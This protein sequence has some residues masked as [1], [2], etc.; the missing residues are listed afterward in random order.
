MTAIADDC[1]NQ[2]IAS[3]PC[4]IQTPRR[5]DSDGNIIFEN[6][7]ADFT[8]ASNYFDGFVVEQIEGNF[9]SVIEHHNIDLGK[10]VSLC[11][12]LITSGQQN[13]T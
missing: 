4:T 6:C 10:E 7:K 13:Y 8:F 11:V 5:E 2:R 9:D 1:H 12:V 3:C